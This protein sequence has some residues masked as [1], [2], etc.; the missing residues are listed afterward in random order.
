VLRGDVGLAV[1]GFSAAKALIADKQLLALASSGAV[2]SA[3]TPTI[4][5]V[6]EQGLQGFDATS[7]NALFVRQDVPQASIAMLNAKLNE[8]LVDPVVKSKLADLGI[9][10]RGSTPAEIGDRLAADIAR[11]SN[12]VDQIGIQRT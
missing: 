8:A 7:W 5:T 6:S 9:T 2:R 10:A 3:V 1:D 12:V 11:W 4:P